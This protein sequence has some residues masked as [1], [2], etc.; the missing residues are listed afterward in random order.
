[1]A[2]YERLSYTVADAVATIRLTRAEAR[3]SLDMTAKRELAEVVERVATDPDVRAVVLTGSG[4]AF[5]AG[6]DVKEMDLNSDPVTSRSRLRTLL[7]TVFLPL[8]EIEKPTIAAVNGHCHG[9]G[10]ALMMA[11]DLA[12]VADDATFSCA[13]TKIGLVPDCGTLYFLPRRVP[14]NVA[15]ELIFTGRRFGAAEAKELGLVNRVVPAAEL[16][17]NAGALAAE[18]AAGPTVALGLAKTLLDRSM[19]LSSRDLAELEAFAI[20]TAFTTEDHLAARA[21]F[22]TRTAPVFHGR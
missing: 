13:F 22:G 3:N 9:S 7:T 20:G 1:M 19:R 8:A 11:C 12:V 2:D 17:E 15:K 6:G 10:L 18:L 14:L 16:E 4:G 5:S 21:A